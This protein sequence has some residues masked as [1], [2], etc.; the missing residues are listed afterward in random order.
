LLKLQRGEKLPEKIII[1]RVNWERERII[2]IK[3]D[4]SVYLFK[5]NLRIL[6]ILI[7]FQKYASLTAIIVDDRTNSM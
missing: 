4:L 1:R 3:F 5:I 6:F 2:G 7:N